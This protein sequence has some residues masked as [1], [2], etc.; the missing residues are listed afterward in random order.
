MHTHLYKREM[1]LV[2]WLVDRTRAPF[3]IMIIIIF[4]NNSTNTT[5]TTTNRDIYI[6]M[7]E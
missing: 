2:G 7:E 6:Y 1:E 3:Y 4:F 5:T